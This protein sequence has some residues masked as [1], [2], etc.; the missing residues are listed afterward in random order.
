M[1]YS[2]LL[3]LAKG[4]GNFI[5]DRIIIWRLPYIASRNDYLIVEL[6]DGK[7]PADPEGTVFECKTA[8]YQLYPAI[9]KGVSTAE[10]KTFSFNR[11]EKQN[12]YITND[13]EEIKILR[14][15]IKTRVDNM[16]TEVKE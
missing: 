13:A 8:L 16:F 3:Q 6:E 1:N 7:E 5:S 2:E 4:W 10:G 9:Y 12:R 15:Y 11:G 14:D